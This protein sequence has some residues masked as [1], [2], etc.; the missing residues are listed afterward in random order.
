MLKFIFSPI[1]DYGRSKLYRY[2]TE[3]PERENPEIKPESPKPTACS[4]PILR[5]EQD[6]TKPEPIEL[7][8]KS[9]SLDV[10]PP[11]SRTEGSE[12]SPSRQQKHSLPTGILHFL[13]S[14]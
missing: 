4:T 9:P 6:E 13:S 11:W 1:Q 12:I 10:S 7:E 2:Q 14:F 8:I 5:I 3:S